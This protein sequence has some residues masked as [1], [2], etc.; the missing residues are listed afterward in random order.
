MF[1]FIK[2]IGSKQ[3]VAITSALEMRNSACR[4]AVLKATELM[5][6]KGVCKSQHS[7]FLCSLSVMPERVTEY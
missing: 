5:V 1:H 6:S 2:L 3:G 7:N 4:R